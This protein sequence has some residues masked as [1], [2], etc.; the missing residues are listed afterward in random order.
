MLFHAR[1]DI[2]EGAHELTGIYVSLNSGLLVGPKWEKS[3]ILLKVEIFFLA[4]FHL[5]FDFLF[6][7]HTVV[8]SYQ[9]VSDEL[10]DI[11]PIFS[12]EVSR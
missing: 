2:E 7:A 8:F 9:L 6:I 5:N 11:S 3:A 4:C 12:F 10:V 1:L